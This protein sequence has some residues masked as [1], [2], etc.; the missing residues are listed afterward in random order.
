MNCT[1]IEK[2]YPE[3]VRLIS[4]TNL[5]GVITYANPAFCEV[6]GYHVDELIGKNHSIVRH[7]DMPPAAFGDLWVHAKDDRPW[8]GLVKNRCRNGDHYWVQAYVTPLFDKHGSKIG[9]QS[10]RT[11]PTDAQI[12][13]AEA[14]YTKLRT[15]K[16]SI[17]PYSLSSRLMITG[18]MAFLCALV[19]VFLPLSDYM[20]AGII[21]AI[22][23]A[24][25]SYQA[26]I[27]KPLKHL[28]DNAVDVYDNALA[29]YVMSGHMNEV[30]CADMANLMLQARLRTVIG[31]VQDSIT[32]LTQFMDQTLS[33]IDQTSN[34]IEKQNLEADMLASAATEMSATAHEIAQ[35]TSQTSHATSQTAD[36]ADGGKGIVEEMIGGIKDLVGEVRL[37]GE[38][39]GE[40]KTKAQAVEQ[41]VD[42]ITEIAEQT[43]LLALN[44]AIEAA[45]AGD[46]G[47][48]FSVVADEV[49][50]LAQRTQESTTE[51]R[52]TIEA[53]QNQVSE[54]VHV[55]ERCGSHAEANIQRAEGVGQ[56]FDEVNAAMLNITDLSTQVAAASEEQSSVSDEVSRNIESIRDVTS[57]NH[58]I[59]KRMKDS[60]VELTNLVT[61]LKSMLQAI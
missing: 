1:G 5:Q 50:T 3:G 42:I 54:T 30:G 58:A 11:R 39:S 52:S 45:R 40:L 36:L 35:N 9:Y 18:L 55:M 20:Q 21:A 33:S 4:T 56:S 38:S 44:A 43:N 16:V 46:Q 6:A 26:I 61:D 7:P 60:S 13:R 51:I 24:F 10:V 37:A 31:R 53:I 22:A 48:G 8:M 17:K 23:L 15:K 12:Q 27:L 32:T 19:S 2:K 28:K 57:E 47:R 14:V 49:R 41:V 34:G 25:I 29:Q 59:A